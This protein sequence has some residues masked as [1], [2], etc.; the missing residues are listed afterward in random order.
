MLGH[1]FYFIGLFLFFLNL[2]KVTSYFKFIETKEWVIK[3]KKVTGKEPLKSDFREENEYNF[4]VYFGCL[5]LIKTIWL[6]CGLLSSNWQ[7]F[8]IT[9][10]FGLIIKKISEK[11]PFSVQ[12]VVGFTFNLFI[13]GLIALL[14]LN[15]FHFHQNLTNWISIWI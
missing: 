3:F 13:S 7:I 1:I 15:H 10:L 6:I 2:S 5:S 9:I 14:V 11:S 8:G 4:F 12:K